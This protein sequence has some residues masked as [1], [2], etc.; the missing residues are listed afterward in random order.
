MSAPRKGPPNGQPVLAAV[1][2]Q[3]QAP[4]SA[5]VASGLAVPFSAVQRCPFPRL[6][7]FAARAR[8][9][10]N[11][12]SVDAYQLRFGLLI[13]LAAGREFECELTPNMPARALVATL[14]QL[15]D[16]MEQLADDCER[17]AAALVIPGEPA[18]AEGA[19]VPLK[20]PRTL[21]APVAGVAGCGWDTQAGACAAAGCPLLGRT[22]AP[23]PAGDVQPG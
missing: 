21:A 10:P 9:A 6:Q 12:K 17:E 5:A 8:V 22:S 11:L 19:P 15:A 20:C 18:A 1:R 4:A 3:A 16:S 13:S 7:A 14:R 23:N 2:S